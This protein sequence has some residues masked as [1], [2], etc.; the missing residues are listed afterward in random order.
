[1]KQKSEIRN[2]KHET[3][4]KFQILNFKFVSNF[5]LRASCLQLKRGFSLIEVVISIFIVGVI[6]FLLQSVL[7]SSVLAR[8]SKSQGIA[9]SIARNEIEVLREG[10]Y[11]ALPPSGS[12]SNEL[13]STIPLATTTRTVSPFN[14]KTKQVVVSIV[15][16]D[17]GS[18]ASSTVSLS[19]LITQ[20]GGLP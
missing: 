6:L 8:I 16:Q 9:L 20:P 12:F 11:D 17:P 18:A 10:G 14:D 1:M 3:N 7:Q 13:L 19:T 2:P 15:W 5:V 4:P